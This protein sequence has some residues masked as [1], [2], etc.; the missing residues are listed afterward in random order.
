M[1]IKYPSKFPEWVQLFKIVKPAIEA[2]PV[3]NAFTLFMAE[4][5]V[6]LVDDDAAVTAADAANDVANEKSRSS[7]EHTEAARLLM[8]R[9]KKNHRACCQ[10]LKSIY[11][12]HVRNLGEWGVTVNNKNKIVYSRKF[13]EHAI[14][15]KA[16]IAKHNTFAAGTSPLQPLIDEEGLDLA[17]NLTQVNDAI[18]VFALAQSDKSKKEEKF[19]ERNLKMKPVK[20]HLRGI[21]QMAIRTYPG[22]RKKAGDLGFTVDSSKQKPRKRTIT[23]EPGQEMVRGNID[24]GSY[25][26]VHDEGQLG[27]RPK[28][29]PSAQLITVNAS[30]KFF[31]QYGYGQLFM[32][33][34]HSIQK[35]TFSIFCHS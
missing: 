4:N 10:N 18:A 35:V 8:K 2:L 16:L 21:G 32:K 20:D 26:I 3:P 11:R 34:T 5:N 15:V 25:I 27:I 31:L 7:E 24:V 14:E 30:K 28:N 33:N 6:S 22:H 29:K 19:E 1:R 9:P 12:S 17:Q 23:L 13:D